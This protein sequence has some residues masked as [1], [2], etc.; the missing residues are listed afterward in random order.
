MTD[1][2]IG[3]I[4]IPLNDRSILTIPVN[5][6]SGTY[7]SD[8]YSNF[9]TYNRIITGNQYYSIIGVNIINPGSGYSVGD[10]L[11][12]TGIFGSEPAIMMISTIN[13]TGGITS[14]SIK[15]NG[16]YPNQ[17][18]I[19]LVKPENI[20]G[21]GKN[22]IVNLTATNNGLN[23]TVSDIDFGNNSFF[24]AAALLLS[25]GDPN[26]VMTCQ[27]N[28]YGDL[29]NITIKNVIY[30]LKKR[31]SIGLPPRLGRYM[32]SDE[33]IETYSKQL[34]FDNNTTLF[35]IAVQNQLI[36]AKV[37]DYINRF[38]LSGRIPS[39]ANIFGA[40]YIGY[41]KY[42]LIAQLQTVDT[43]GNILFANGY[44]Q[45]GIPTVD[46]QLNSDFISQLSIS[47]NNAKLAVENNNTCISIANQIN[48]IKPNSISS[49]NS[50]L[51]NPPSTTG[52]ANVIVSER[53][54]DGFGVFVGGIL[55]NTCVYS[56]GSF[57]NAG[58]TVNNAIF[59]S[60]D[61][62]VYGVSA[63]LLNSGGYDSTG[64][65]VLL[66]NNGLTYNSN[67]ILNQVGVTDNNTLSFLTGTGTNIGSNVSKSLPGVSADQ[68]L[69]TNINYGSY[70]IPLNNSN[71]GL[72]NNNP[73]NIL[74]SVFVQK[75]YGYIGNITLNGFTYA[76]FSTPQA[77]AIAHVELI[78]SIITSNT[79]TISVISNIWLTPR[80][81]SS[82]QIAV[83]AQ[84]IATALGI[85]ID[86]QI[87]PDKIL[88]FAAAQSLQEIGGDSCKYFYSIVTANTI[89]PSQSITSYDSVKASIA[90]STVKSSIA[91]NSPTN[92]QSNV[93]LKSDQS[94]IL[95]LMSTTNPTITYQ[96]S[97]T[98]S[99]L[100]TTPTVFINSIPIYRT[101]FQ[102]TSTME[103]IIPSYIMTET[104]NNLIQSTQFVTSNILAFANNFESAFN[105]NPIGNVYIQQLNSNLKIMIESAQGSATN[106][107]PTQTTDPKLTGQ[108]LSENVTVVSQPGIYQAIIDTSI[109]AVTDDDSFI[110]PELLNTPVDTTD[111]ELAAASAAAV[112]ATGNTIIITSSVSD[113]GSGL[114]MSISAGNL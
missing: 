4:S 88:Q 45:T 96:Q 83:Y 62:T 57:I 18:K 11:A 16:K 55:S 21:V 19:L 38:S 22:C 84:N 94:A 64:T 82:S 67:G 27:S 77:G 56:G 79:P 46:N 81:Y 65:K 76:Q 12:F 108:T 43:V 114:D 42:I 54:V 101:A 80:N 1:N 51:N 7:S 86:T 104:A 28:I 29:S 91:H 90:L 41:E 25:N 102:S 106:Q 111:S 50:L 30:N 17:P 49:P 105:A 59:N 2:Y 61:Q 66:Y 68:T 20:F 26:A 40:I 95:S 99:P 39:D 48:N 109:T 13:S 8:L 72:S 5:P 44:Y 10:I 24:D 85:T 75:Q 110:P 60:L 32:L 78:K 6:N 73:A 52:N 100:T 87:T 47:I 93:A 74:D 23:Q 9:N 89:P 35:T 34:K 113:P 69:L 31:R 97:M 53:N 14:L 36:A 15:N 63:A 103:S 37:N 107:F 112:A 3:N 98:T 33:D 71:F 58:T 92:T 70:N